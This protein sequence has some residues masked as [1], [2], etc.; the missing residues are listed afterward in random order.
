MSAPLERCREIRGFEALV[1]AL[2]YDSL[3][4]WLQDLIVSEI[5]DYI[6]I[7]YYE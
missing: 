4:D 3:T 7:S 1:G 6:K 5:V 2:G